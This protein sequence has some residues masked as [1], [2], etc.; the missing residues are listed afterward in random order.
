MEKELELFSED[1]A[2]DS[3][4][5]GDQGKDIVFFLMLTSAIGFVISVAVSFFI[6][7]WTR[8]SFDGVLGKISGTANLISK[9][10]FSVMRESTKVKDSAVEQSAAIQESVSALSEMSSMIS[11]TGQNVRISM[12]TAVTAHDKSAEGKKSWSICPMQCL[13]FK[14]QIHLCKIFQ[15]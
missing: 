6:F 12:D 13:Q 8:R 10:S 9:S 15:K 3:K 11:Q 1:V 2:N 14:K 7:N 5:T 4:M